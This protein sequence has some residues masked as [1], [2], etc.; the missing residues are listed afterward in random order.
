MNTCLSIIVP[1]FNGSPYIRKLV[2]NLDEL[3]FND[4]EII[5]I[6]DG[7]TDDTLQQI[8]EVVANNSKYK[9]INQV[10]QGVATARN[11][12]ID[13]AKGTWLFF[14]DADDAITPNY[15]DF[16]HEKITFQE[17]CAE[18]IVINGVCDDFGGKKYKR[19]NPQN[20][21]KTFD[22]ATSYV[23]E[24][25]IMK[26]VW[27]KL[28]LRSF[29]VKNNVKFESFHI[30]ED[31]LFNTKVCMQ[32]PTLINIDSGDYHY[33]QNPISATKTYTKDN[34]LGRL[35]VIERIREMLPST[36][37]NLKKVNYLYME[38]FLYQ[39]LKHIDKLSKLERS[40][41]IRFLKKERE[42]M[43]FSHI[44]FLPISAK[45]KMLFYCLIFR[46][47]YWS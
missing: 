33:Y 42:K 36:E 12:G 22:D 29:I 31:F 40:S 10:N 38:F 34:L 14:L 17:T 25:K 15:F 4:Y 43:T 37:I 41:I 7:S 8:E 26:Y 39:T 5:I 27:G 45:G 44:P 16:I 47:L 35:Q 19:W 2:A 9:V 28:Y 3:A 23:L 20:F 46:Y 13:N 21:D 6:N 18:L 1:V 24:T 32:N 11:T 30:A